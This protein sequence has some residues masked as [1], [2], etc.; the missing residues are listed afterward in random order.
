MC[1]IYVCVATRS[2]H[3]R[4]FIWTI[5]VPTTCNSQICHIHISYI[6]LWKNL[7]LVIVVLPGKLRV[8]IIVITQIAFNSTL[9]S[10]FNDI[11]PLTLWFTV[12]ICIDIIWFDLFCESSELLFSLGLSE[13]V[14]DGL[15]QGTS[16]LLFQVAL[17]VYTLVALIIF[18]HV[19]VLVVLL[20]IRNWG[21]PLINVVVV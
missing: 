14:L 20:S 15:L 11:S 8:I 12:S 17:V 19:V 2:R 6:C 9:F 1:R 21:S 16:L 18:I 5:A 10:F 13:T 3:D 7:V 4:D